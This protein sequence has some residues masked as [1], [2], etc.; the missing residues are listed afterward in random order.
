[1]T[2]RED[3]QDEVL[4]I[5]ARYKETR[6]ITQ[7]FQRQNARLRVVADQ[8]VLYAL[9]KEFFVGEVSLDLAGAFLE[10]LSDDLRSQLVR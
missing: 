1:L 4:H 10:N 2:G 5:E 8:V 6:Q 7:N 9:Q 3:V